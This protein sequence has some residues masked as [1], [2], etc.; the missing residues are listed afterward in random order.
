MKRNDW[1]WIAFVVW[2]G[3]GVAHDVLVL[4]LAALAA[5]AAVLWPLLP[6]A[7]RRREATP[8]AEA[9]GTRREADAR[10]VDPETD[11]LDF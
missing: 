1:A 6:A 8:A 9:A 5:I 2:L 11:L 3:L 10:I 7:L 4:R